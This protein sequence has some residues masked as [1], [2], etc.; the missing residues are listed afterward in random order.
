[1]ANARIFVLM[2]QLSTRGQSIQNELSLGS[3]G[4]EDSD[5]GSGRWGGQERG[6]EKGTFT[7]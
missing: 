6:T 5:L 2:V 4:D 3:K 7:L 1:M